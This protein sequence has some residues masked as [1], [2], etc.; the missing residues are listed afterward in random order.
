MDVG[1]VM[2]VDVGERLP[3]QENNL[4]EEVGQEGNMGEKV[5]N[6]SNVGKELVMESMYVRRLIKRIRVLLLTL[7][8]KVRAVVG[9][10][11]A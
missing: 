7:G 1:E 2:D 11:E 5:V 9:G 3:T 6:E 10:M 8:G 4:G